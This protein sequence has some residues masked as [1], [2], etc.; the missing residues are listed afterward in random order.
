MWEGQPRGRHPT[1]TG[2]DVGMCG[3]GNPEEGQRT[4]TGEDVGMCGVDNNGAN[5]VGMSLKCVDFLQ[6]IVVEDSDLH[7]VRSSHYPTLTGH[8]L[9]CTH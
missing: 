2:E 6:G 9:G 3:R 5:V 1:T 4:T 7:I 8:K